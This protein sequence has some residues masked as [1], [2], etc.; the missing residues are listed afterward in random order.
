MKPGRNDPCPCGSGK[1]YK[2]CCLA[3][4]RA[5]PDSPSDRAWARVRRAIDGLPRE[6]DRFVAEVYA[7][8]DVEEAWDE[9]T[10]WEGFELD[11]ESPLMAIFMPWLYHSW[12][13]DPYESDVA[14]SFAR[15]AAD[16]RV[17]GASRRETRP[18]ARTLSPCVPRNA[19]QLP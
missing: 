9:F 15:P 19:V 10:L 5:A 4:E 13:P 2:N 3:A 11:D 18:A 17:P 1:K 6:L 8:E 14:V 16:G 7:P 12:Q